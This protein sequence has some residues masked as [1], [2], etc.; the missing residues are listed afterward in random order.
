MFNVICVDGKHDKD[1]YYNNYY[2]NYFDD[3]VENLW[4]VDGIW[5]GIR[6]PFTF[7]F[8]KQISVVLIESFISRDPLHSNG[9]WTK[10]KMFLT[11]DIISELE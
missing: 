9:N 11:E 7:D 1:N 5:L 6:G 4:I 8:F 3:I 10:Q 2:N